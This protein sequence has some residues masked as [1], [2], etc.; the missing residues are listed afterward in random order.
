MDFMIREVS[1]YNEVHQ[2]DKSWV[3]Y[4][5]YL[6]ILYYVNMFVQYDQC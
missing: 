4:D 5:I 3:V 6:K 2:V 1:G